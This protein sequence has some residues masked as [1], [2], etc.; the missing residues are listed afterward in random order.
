MLPGPRTP[1]ALGDPL[2]TEPRLTVCSAFSPCD[3]GGKSA[4]LRV[5]ATPPLSAPLQHGLR[6]LPHLLPAPQFRLPYGR[7]TLGFPQRVI[8]AY[9][10]PQGAPTNGRRA[11]LYTGEDDACGGRPVTS[12]AP[13]PRALVALEPLSRLS[14]A[15][16]TMRNTKALVTFP[17]ASQ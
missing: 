14:S 4:P 16:L 15:R 5:G 8:Q 10:V 7:P 9:H 3:T 2:E 1:V 12:P 13:A 11:P 6:F 17:V